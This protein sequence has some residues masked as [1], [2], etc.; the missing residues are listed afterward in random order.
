VKVVEG[1]GSDLPGLYS[2]AVAE[3]DKIPGAKNFPK[4]LVKVGQQ[5]VFAEKVKLKDN[6]TGIAFLVHDNGMS[7]GDL[8]KLRKLVTLSLT[9]KMDE[10]SHVILLPKRDGL[11]DKIAEA[12]Q[13]MG[14]S[15][16]EISHQGGQRVV[17]SAPKGKNKTVRT[18]VNLGKG[19]GVG[20]FASQR[21]VVQDARAVFVA[22]GDYKTLAGTIFAMH[23]NTVIGVLETG[24]MSGKLQSD[25]LKDAG[26]D[27]KA[28][29]IYDTDP[30]R[31]YERVREAV[32]RKSSISKISLKSYS[33]SW[34]D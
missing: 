3:L 26:K 1:S 25:I 10:R 18:T 12:A 27:V 33:S 17:E 28:E 30:V 19:D 14:V 13:N 11:S 23:E 8:L 5:Q 9:Q 34:D 7:E 4:N 22:G 29:L 20:E 15:S 2:A 16:F 32:V 21:E 24:G 31:L 6:Y